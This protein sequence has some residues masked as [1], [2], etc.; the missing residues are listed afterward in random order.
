MRNK[1][2][3]V[4]EVIIAHSCMLLSTLLLRSSFD[5]SVS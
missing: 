4:F 2:G 3:K 1:I 5:I